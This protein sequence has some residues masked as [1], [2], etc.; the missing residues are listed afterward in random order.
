MSLDA[1][2]ITGCLWIFGGAFVGA[3]IILLRQKPKTA[4]KRQ[5]AL[6]GI[7]LGLIMII[8]GIIVAYTNSTPIY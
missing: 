3:G 4:S 7:I 5:S 1:F 2:V 8:I 6:T